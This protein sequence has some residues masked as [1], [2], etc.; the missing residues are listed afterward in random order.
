VR[1]SACVLLAVVLLLPSRGRAEEAPAAPETRTEVEGRR[2][3]RQ[4]AAWVAG[5]RG[6]AGAPRTL[7]VDLLDVEI[8]E[9]KDSHDG[10]LRIAVPRMAPDPPA[11]P[12]GDEAAPRRPSKRRSRRASAICGSTPRCPRRGSVP[13]AVRSGRDRSPIPG[14]RPPALGKCRRTV[15]DSK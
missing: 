9:G 15:T 6:A 11:S 12:A 3:F 10:Y 4:A 8:R 1:A 2:L 14:V 13:A 5:R 7:Y